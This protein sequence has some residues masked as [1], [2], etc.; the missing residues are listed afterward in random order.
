[1]RLFL[2]SFHLGSKPEKLLPLLR[3]GR[4]VAV[5]M[6][7]RDAKEP[8]DRKLKLAK[9]IKELNDLGFLPEEL[10]LREFFGEKEALERKLSDFAAVYIA[11][12]NTFMLRRAMFDSGFDEL[13]KG[14]LKSDKIVYAGDSAAILVL[15]R[16]LRGLECW[17]V[18]GLVNK[19]YGKEI[20]WEG[21]EITER[22]L[23]PHAQ[24][25]HRDHQIVEKFIQTLKKQGIPITPL[26]DGQVFVQI[27]DKK[28]IIG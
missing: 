4:R 23:V 16:S 22:L 10:D 13:I 3:G 19:V 24:S 17:D 25:D 9:R 18:P 12:G 26:K 7:A 15:H 8:D 11:G 1:M 2:S 20:I 21:L 5:I 14:L 6:N 27:G 28:E